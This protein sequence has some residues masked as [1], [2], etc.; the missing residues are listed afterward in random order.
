MKVAQLLGLWGPWQRQVCRDMNCLHHRSYGTLRVFFQ[1]S[2][3]WWSEGLFGQSFSVA[4]PIQALRVLAPLPG[5]LLCCSERQAHRGAPLAGVL[6]YSLAHQ[7]LKGAPWVGS[8]SVVQCVKCLMGQ[9]LYCSAANTGIWGERGY[10]EGSTCYVWLSSIAWLPWLP[11]FPPQVFP[12]T[13]SFLTS[14]W[15]ISPQ[16]TAALALGLLHNP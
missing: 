14:P 7:S 12:T 1:V 15:S 13:V 6:L 11:G 8:Y 5:A 3:S 10:E 9:P 16:S 4:P 2:W